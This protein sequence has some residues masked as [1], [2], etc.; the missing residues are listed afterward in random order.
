MGEKL[1]SLNVSS[2]TSFG[3]RKQVAIIASGESVLGIINEIPEIKKKYF[4]ITMNYAP[5]A[6]QSDMNV[7]SD[8]RVT[9]WLKYNIYQNGKSGL[10]C[11]HRK[12]FSADTA[13]IKKYIDYSYPQEAVRGTGTIGAVIKIVTDV[14]QP[15]KILLF[16][17]DLCYLKY[18]KWYDKYIDYDLKMCP[19]NGTNYLQSIKK[20]DDLI[21]KNART[22]EGFYN[23][24]PVSKSELL[25]YCGKHWRDL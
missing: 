17:Y 16:G 22:L 13:K 2:I 10:Y 11:T 9:R 6:I 14:L 1:H 3:R 21:K 8:N 24:S 18:R 23:M 4:I 5:C 12:A 20:S 7:W 19:E 15:C 25:P